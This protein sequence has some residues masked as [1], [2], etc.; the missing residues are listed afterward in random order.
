MLFNL[1]KKHLIDSRID[2]KQIIEINFDAIEN[3]KYRDP[4][5]VLNHVNTQ[6][7]DNREYY[8][9]LDE[10]QLLDKFESVLNSL[11]KKNNVDIYVT[12]SNAKFLS[13]DILTGFRGRG[14]QVHIY[15]LSFSEF[16][17]VYQGD[18]Y[19]AFNDYLFTVGSRRF[20]KWLNTV[21]KQPINPICIRKP[22]LK[23][24]LIETELKMI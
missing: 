20:Q 23:I 17:S 12:G 5:T 19:Q 24:L 9:L 14:D 21:K 4:L 7:V 18:K 8:L 2:E 13:K 15:P 3:E 10:V 22:I 6:I 1:F 16:L 11:L